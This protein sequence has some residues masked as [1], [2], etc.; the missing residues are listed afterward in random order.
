MKN[1]T[2]LTLSISLSIFLFA[3]NA[4]AT[5]GDMD[6]G[7]KCLVQGNP[8]KPVVVKS[9][10][11]KDTSDTTIDEYILK[12]VEDLKDIFGSIFR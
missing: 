5:C 9:I 6:S 3:G 7:T 4:L 2:K 8:D 10:D 12:A 1:I 11:K